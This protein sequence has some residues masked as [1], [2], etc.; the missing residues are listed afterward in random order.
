MFS[1]KEIG[2]GPTKL[3]NTL[4]ANAVAIRNP[5]RSAV[6]RFAEDCAF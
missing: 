3:R 1:S 4:L 6:I 2:N 5:H